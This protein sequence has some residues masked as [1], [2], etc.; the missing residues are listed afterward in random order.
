MA[1]PDSLGRDWPLTFGNAALEG[2]WPFCYNTR[3]FPAK[4]L[5]RKS[6]F[7]LTRDERV[8]RS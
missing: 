1:N 8:D 5:D 6:R 7:T 2:R 4:S 3:Q